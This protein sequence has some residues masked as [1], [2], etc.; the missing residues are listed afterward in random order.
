MARIL[1]L[2]HW[3][4][5][6]QVPYTARYSRFL[7]R[8]EHSGLLVYE[9]AY[10]HSLE[11]SLVASD[12][13]VEGPQGQKPVTRVS[14]FGVEFGTTR[15]VVDEIGI[16]FVGVESSH[17]IVWTDADGR[18]QHRSPDSSGSATIALRDGATVFGASAVAAADR[19]IDDWLTRCPV[20]ADQWVD[21]TGF[22]WWVLGVNTLRFPHPDGDSHPVVPSKLGYVG[23]WQWDAYF[24]AIGLRH[25][26]TQLAAEQLEIALT[27]QRP[28]GQLPDV[29]HESGVLASSED[30]PESDLANLRAMASPSLAYS[31]V[32]LTKPP[33][34]AL[35]V[36]LVAE[37]VPNLV[38][39]H[40]DTLIR[41]QQWWYSKS[42]RNSRPVY[43][44]PYSS[45]LDD[46]PIFDHET[47]IESPDLTSYLINSDT[48]L[49]GWL[50]QLGRHDEAAAATGRAHRSLERLVD[51]WQ[52]DGRF[53][54]SIGEAGNVVDSETIVSLMP[55]LAASLPERYVNELCTS[56]EDPERFATTRRLPTVA[57]RD[58]GFSS[59]RM[60]RG[61]VWINTNW[62]VAYGLR[63]HGCAEL[64]DRIEQ[65]SLDLVAASGPCEYFSPLDGAKPPRA[66]TCFSWSAALMVDM[67]VRATSS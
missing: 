58:E 49:A 62:L 8:R 60:W 30:L 53:F 31:R 57:H 39:R 29:V 9:A 22:C 25:G 55:L 50:E 66:T 10:E 54:A 3:F 13:R 40:I 41:A 14:P 59:E 34:A 63:L 45:G 6:D 21:I 42:A 18:P 17:Q 44:H 47:I 19:L 28:D 43:L 7:V 52:T 38:E 12:V 4:D 48:L 27:A 32:P 61:P 33:L 23:L 20:V 37:Q 5:L 51:T 1:D 2:S 36:S 67:A 65:E 11:E 26:D 35:A 15:M 16:H 46:S 56:I 24:I 64:A